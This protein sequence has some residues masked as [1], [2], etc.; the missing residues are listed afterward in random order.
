[1]LITLVVPKIFNDYERYQADEHNNLRNKILLHIHEIDLGVNRGIYVSIQKHI[2][3]WT[4]RFLQFPEEQPYVWYMCFFFL[5]SLFTLPWFRAEFIPSG[6]DQEE[7]MGYF[8]LWGLLFEQQWV[9]MADTWLYAIFQ[10]TFNVGL[11]VLFF[12]WKS[13]NIHELRCKGVTAPQDTV[14]SHLYNRLYFQ[15][16]ILVYWLWRAKGLS[17]LATLYGG[18]WHTLILNLLVWWLIAVAVVIV[19]GKQGVITAIQT[20]KRAQM[21]PLGGGLV[22]CAGCRNAT[23]E[24]M[25]TDLASINAGGGEDSQ[26]LVSDPAVA[27]LSTNIPEESRGLLFDDS[28]ASS[29]DSSSAESP[30]KAFRRNAMK[31]D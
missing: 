19:I 16:L 15:V 6:K 9:P 26:I 8:Y 21:E 4:H 5:L 20:K 22:I 29:N 25:N 12:I 13:T 23:S 1:M 31:K 27:S 11:F 17:E 30:R 3:T 28:E 2:Y 24:S 14:S 7:R 10:L 18:V